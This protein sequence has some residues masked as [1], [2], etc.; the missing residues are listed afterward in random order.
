MKLFKQTVIM[1]LCFLITAVPAWSQSNVKM[2]PASVSADVGE[3]FTVKVEIENT[4]N[5]RGISVKVAFDPAVVQ[6]QQ[7]IGGAFMRS[8]GTTFA[9]SDK[10][11]TEGWA[12]YDES[13][14]GSGD[15]AQGSGTVCEIE[16]EAV[17]PGA[18][19]LTFDTAD[20]RD[21]DNMPIP[22]TTESGAC[23]SLPQ[24]TGSRLLEPRLGSPPPDLSLKSLG[25]VVRSLKNSTAGK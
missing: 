7:I 21:F 2:E 25:D 6:A 10:D 23:R 19:S 17:G 16:F 3:T 14:L 18:S 11:N 15:M 24:Y 1:A 12:Q 8:F 13:I 22:A 5:L 9:F 4:N 20:L